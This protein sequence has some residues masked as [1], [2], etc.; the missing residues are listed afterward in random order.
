MPEQ[1]KISS[2]LVEH[3]FRRFFDSD[4]VK[5][6]GETLTTV[7][8]A[9]SAVAV[10]GLMVSFFLQNQY[11]RRSL[12]GSIEDQYFF[13]LFSFVV[14]G[15]AAI[16]EWEM[17]F[18]DRL[19]FLI[20]SPLPVKPLQLL[21]AKGTALIIF[22]SIFLAGSNVFGALVLP[23]ISKGSLFRHFLAH[24]VAV[25]LAGLFAS[26]FFLALAGV[27]LCVLGAA[28]FRA[29]SP[30]VQMF[31]VTA[32]LLLMMH[33]VKVGNDMH[34]LLT[35]PLGATQWVPSIWF[36]GVYETLLHGNA[37]PAFARPMAGYA[38]RG[39]LIVTA[40]VLLTYP[41]AWVRMRRMAVEG[42]SVQHYRSSRLLQAAMHRLVRRP[43]ERAAFH[44]IGQT[45]TR[46]NHYQVYLAMYCGT[47]LAL[48]TACAVAL[49]MRG[50]GMHLALSNEGLHAVM[51][52]LLF[53]VIAGLHTAFAFPMNLA[54]GWIF[55]VTGVSVDECAGAAWAW[56]FFASV[57]VMSAI[58]GALRIAGWDGRH[59]LVQLVCGLCVAV[60][61]TDG[62]SFF[63]RSVPFNQP[64]MPGKTSLPLML[65]LYVGVFPPFIFGVIYLEKRLELNLG[66]LAL[67][68]VA[69]ILIHVGLGMLR[70]GPPEIEEDLEGY[71][72]QFQLLGLSIE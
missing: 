32:L 27:L 10:P 49:P 62:F 47:G 65:T 33:Y 28:R 72:G 19:D 63:Q 53:W 29:V 23:L 31:S 30:V 68:G 64:R 25:L 45:I 3:F 52:L 8:R 71:D 44:F 61:L 38:I 1:H 12:W 21:A 70:N 59:L 40:V 15:A 60:L 9:V 37:A 46:N 39:I 5:I 7:I 51:P 56:V 20:L 13:V 6:E 54:A 55:R 18:P 66:K 11:P 17:L 14:M 58:L 69:A 42:L 43:G 16:F 36:L 22:L 4:T 50:L 26:L 35:E 48:A 41:T 2:V 24:S 34:A 57:F 67:L